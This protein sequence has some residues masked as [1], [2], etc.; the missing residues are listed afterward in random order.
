MRHD[1]VKVPLPLSQPQ[2]R[3]FAGASPK[4][5]QRDGW[6]QLPRTK[7]ADLITE[8]LIANKIPY[9]FGICG[10]GN[11]GMLDSL[12]AAR[13]RIKLISPRH[14][15]GNHDGDQVAGFQGRARARRSI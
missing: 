7:G 5:R 2:K 14:R 6:R 12:Y 15:H 9:V 10:H 4:R 8:F 11:V 13:D 3:E 1:I